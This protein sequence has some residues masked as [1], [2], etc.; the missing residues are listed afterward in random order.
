M[1]SYTP[2]LKKILK[3]YKCYLFGQG[4]GDHEFWYS[5]ING[6]KFVVA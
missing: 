4:K 5:P 3:A 6:H 2:R 1:S